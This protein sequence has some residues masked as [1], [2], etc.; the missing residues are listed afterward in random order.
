MRMC[1]VCLR[2]VWGKCVRAR[3]ECRESFTCAKAAELQSHKSRA[4]AGGALQCFW[5]WVGQQTKQISARLL[6]AKESL[7]QR[8]AGTFGGRETQRKKHIIS[9]RS[10]TRAARDRCIYAF[11]ASC[12]R[13]VCAAHSLDG[14]C[15]STPRSAFIK[16]WERVAERERERERESEREKQ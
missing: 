10:A 16:M 8:T 15:V 5:I 13:G 3:S 2:G 7:V 11:R 14:A 4:G 9:S 1:C 12:V 6:P